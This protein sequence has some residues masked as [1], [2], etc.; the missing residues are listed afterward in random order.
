MPEIRR[1]MLFFSTKAGFVAAKHLQSLRAAGRIQEGDVLGGV[2]CIHPACL[3]VSLADN[4]RAMNLDT[5]GALS[6]ESHQ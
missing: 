4:L 3:E 2:S 5:V 1:D 6:I